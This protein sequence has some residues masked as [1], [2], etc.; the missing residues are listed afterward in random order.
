MKKPA[1]ILHEIWTAL[2][3]KRLEASSGISKPSE[4]MAAFHEELGLLGQNIRYTEHLSAIPPKDVHVMITGFVQAARM[5]ASRNSM[6]DP[7]MHRIMRDIWAELGLNTFQRDC[8]I[9]FPE[10]TKHLFQIL[11]AVD[12]KF[13]SFKSGV[14][15]P[16]P[17]LLAFYENISKYCHYI[18]ES[19]SHKFISESLNKELTDAFVETVILMAKDGKAD[20]SLRKN[21]IAVFAILD[22]PHIFCRFE[23]HFPEHD[24]QGRT[25][26]AGDALRESPQT[27][28]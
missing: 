11:V 24:A 20:N 9:F 15:I 12:R 6:N 14:V 13:M 22:L 16:S 4:F 10:Q 27:A 19:M 28:A 2:E 17:H 21:A 25:I 8:E 18:C 23:S 26:R 7:E 3:R 1:E 5:V